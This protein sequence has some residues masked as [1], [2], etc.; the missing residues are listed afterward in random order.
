MPSS[1]KVSLLSPAYMYWAKP[2]CFMSLVQLILWAFAL[3][4]A[5]AGSNSAARMAIIAI[6][7]SSSIKV[8]AHTRLDSLF[9]RLLNDTLR[10][11]SSYI[12]RPTGPKVQAL[13]L[14]FL[15]GCTKD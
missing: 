14:V 1:G 10:F 8:N 2:H 7:T 3:A 6:T 12:L 11:P 13:L 5:S 4:L 15:R 9:I